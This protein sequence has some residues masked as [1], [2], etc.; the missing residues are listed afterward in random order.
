MKLIAEYLER[1]EQ[2]ERMAAAETNLEASRRMKEQADAYYKLAAKRARVL[3]LPIPP[4]PPAAIG[5]GLS[6]DRRG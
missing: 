1:C 2:F 6:A 3:N 5:A 4:R